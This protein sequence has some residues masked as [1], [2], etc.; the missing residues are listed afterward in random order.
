[1]ILIEFLKVIMKSDSRWRQKKAKKEKYWA[2]QESDNAAWSLI[3]TE[4]ALFVD[5]LILGCLV[6]LLGQIFFISWFT[7]IVFQI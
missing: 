6:Y 3:L 2:C 5:I 1:M 7:G 4:S